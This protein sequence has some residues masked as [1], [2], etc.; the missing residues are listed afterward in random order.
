LDAANRVGQA[1]QVAIKETQLAAVPET[2]RV[3]PISV[4]IYRLSLVGSAQ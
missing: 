2:I 4:N 3:A 1:P